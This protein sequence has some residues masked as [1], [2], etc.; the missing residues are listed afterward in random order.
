[1]ETDHRTYIRCYCGT[2]IVEQ[3]FEEIW[4]V[5]MSILNH[6]EDMLA[7]LAPSKFI[8]NIRKIDF[9][10]FFLKKVFDLIV[11]FNAHIAKNF[12]LW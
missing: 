5:F 11:R 10:L 4:N 9:F 6:F 3:P 8:I 2:S 12:H 1:M 7:N